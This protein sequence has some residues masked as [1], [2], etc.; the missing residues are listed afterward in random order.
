[1]SYIFGSYGNGYFN[2]C[3]QFTL[4][5]VGFSALTLSLVTVDAGKYLPFKK[6]FSAVS[7]YSYTMYL[8]H[9][10]VLNSTYTF[11]RYLLT[12]FDIGT[13]GF[14]LAFAVY[15][16]AVTAVSMAIYAIIDRPFMNYRKK[17]VFTGS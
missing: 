8:Y 1:V 9:L 2:V 11:L 17:L 12:L 10:L 7:K 3:W 15:F 5:G 13:P 14:L 6:F 16:A 4:T